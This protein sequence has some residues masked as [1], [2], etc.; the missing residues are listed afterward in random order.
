[1]IRRSTLAV[2]SL[3]ALAAISLPVQWFL[4]NRSSDNDNASIYSYH[5]YLT[6]LPYQN[7]DHRIPKDKALLK[8]FKA[9]YEAGPLSAPVPPTQ[10]SPYT[11][12]DVIS[13]LP[14]FHDVFGVVIYDPSTDTFM[15]H[16]SNNMRWI[17]GCHKL[18]TSFQALA[19]S[20]RTMFPER[21]K[22]DGNSPPAE[23]ALAI[24]SGDYP[25]VGHNDCYVG[26]E[27]TPCV[28]A[29]LA[30]VLQFGSA[31]KSPE[32][33]PSMI[34]MPM[35][36]IN[37]VSCFQTFAAHQMVC[38]YYQAR[39][40]GNPQGLVFEETVGV[41]WDD[42]IPSVVWRGTDFSYL[43]RLYPRLR[44]PDFEMDV[45]SKLEKLTYEYNVKV[46]ATRAMREVYDQ[47][48]PRWKSVIWTAEAERE[49][50][51]KQK[52]LPED[53]EEVV[54]P[55]ANMKF[56]AAMHVG[57]K[58]P[59]SEIPYYQE[60]VEHGIPASGDGM[61][62]ETLARYKYHIDTGGGGGT[63][64]SGTL[65]K[66][67][68]PGLL[69]HHETPM[70][71]YLHDKMVKWVH[72][73]PIKEDLSDLKEK[74]D[75]A[76][77]H[78][79]LAKQISDNATRLVKS[80]GTQEGFSIMFNEFYETPLRAVVEAFQ[81]SKRRDSG[82][83]DAMVNNDLRPIMQCSGYYSHDCEGLVKDVTFSQAARHGRDF[84]RSQRRMK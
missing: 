19:H 27:P 12:D 16:Y 83:L 51:E 31:F 68:L 80:L 15:L 43:H 29:K 9:F 70:K 34:A 74:F 59:T 71:D 79:E 22:P 40:P 10:I 7:D 72:Y 35:A 67:G 82:W 57:V 64:W 75:W 81:P 23:L 38:P 36:Q 66:L 18:V 77:S 30:P 17:A 56:A 33:F 73:V 49:A 78:P 26:L 21:F 28:P 60:F 41:G 50:D 58:T 20:L 1:M 8:K 47:L 42:L 24:S 44:Q 14:T 5:R 61:S 55:W 52:A 11:L 2:M 65:E 46:A 54:V 3:A 4:L 62:L 48:I 37:H 32:I 63:T 39:S 84:E 13:V 53:S 76:E 25:G 6:L 45:G 69:F